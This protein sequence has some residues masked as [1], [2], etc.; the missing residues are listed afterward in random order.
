MKYNW[1]LP[2][3]P[4]FNFNLTEIE[5]DLFAFAGETGLVS[6]LLQ[7]IPID[8]QIATIINIMV[9]EAIKTSE[10][11]GEN[12]SRQDVVSSIKNRLGIHKASHIIKDVKA[13]GAGELMVNIRETYAE[14]LS[15]EKLFE[16]HTL[17]MKGSPGI[18]SGAWRKGR[19]A[20]QVISGPI[21]KETIH[22]E[23]PP[24][25]AVASEMKQFIQWFNETA[26]GSIKEIKKA[27]VRS[28][29]AHLY[30]E[31]IHPFEDGNGRIGRAIT[32]KALSQ[33]I[34]RPVV[35]SLS[36]T[37]EADKK[38]Y[39]NALKEAQKSTDITNWIKYFT[40]TLLSAQRETK[41]L[42]EFTLTKSRF[43]DR[44]KEVLNERQL[45]VINKMLDAGPEGFKGGM[46]AKKYMSITKSSKATATRDLQLLLETKALRVEGGGRSTNYSLNI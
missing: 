43:F 2:N 7:A 27:P 12:L 6:G 15:G 38:C 11:E 16:W 45:K 13:K 46:T 31:S 5:D 17:L 3:W 22:F 23:A 36:R 41:Q 25:T 9:T 40:K 33:T 44:H 14:T 29:I 19:S 34:G 39:Y 4:D 26:P 8:L 20:M 30:F 28:A 35:L 24:S 1:Q 10:I 21:G 18:T 42:I 37:I 32:E